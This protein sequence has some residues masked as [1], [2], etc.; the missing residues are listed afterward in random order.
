MEKVFNIFIYR[1][2]G[3][4]FS[5]DVVGQIIRIFVSPHTN[6]I[7]VYAQMYSVILHPHSRQQQVPISTPTYQYIHSNHVQTAV[8]FLPWVNKGG[9]ID[10]TLYA[11]QDTTHPHPFPYS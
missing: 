10:K 8:V 6:D 5:K 9:K 3:F 4:R 2:S 11:I 1:S 7:V